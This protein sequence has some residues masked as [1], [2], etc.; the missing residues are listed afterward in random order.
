MK[1]H[2]YNALVAEQ[3]EHRQVDNAFKIAKN[4]IAKYQAEAKSLKGSKVTLENTNNELR[5]R[6]N[7]ALAALRDA[8]RSSK[9]ERS[10]D[11]TEQTK[12]QI[13]MFSFRNHKFAR[14]DELNGL[15]EQL[16]TDL[17]DRLDFDQ[18]KKEDYVRIYSGVVSQEL[19]NRRQ[20]VQ[21]RC[22]EACAGKQ[23][24]GHDLPT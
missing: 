3:K 24:I 12:R 10:K 19:S 9:N 7:D 1:T 11:V 15:C 8:G 17:D 16:Y 23:N 6:L 18:L 13:K 5:A 22:Q 21:T 2:I 14:D 20:Y 4:N